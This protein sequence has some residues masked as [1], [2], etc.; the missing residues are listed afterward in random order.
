MLTESLLLAGAGR[1]AR[2]RPRLP[3][4]RLALGHDRTTSTTRRP[5]GWRSTIDG[6]VLAVTVA[7]T[8]RWPRW[9]PACCRPGWRRARNVVEVL[10]EGG[11]GN[12]SRAISLVTRGLVV[13][14]IV[15]TCVLLIGSL[16]QLRSILEAAATSTT[17]TTRRGIMSARMGLMDG[18]YPTP[19]SRKLFY[20]RLLRELRASRSSRPWRSPA[21]CG[22]CSRG[23]GAGRDRGQGLPRQAR[24][25]ERQLRAGVARLLRRASD[26]SCSRAALFTDDDIDAEAA[27]GDRQRGVRAESTSAARARSAGASARATADARRTARG[28]PSS[29]SCRRCGCS[30]RSTTRT[31]TTPAS[32]CRSTRAVRPGPRGADG[33]PVRHGRS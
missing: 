19:E 22:W 26:R 3:V 31:W 24:P 11:R 28:G 33:E 21:G 29:A 12:T 8:R 30:G 10:R 5:R 16:L 15:V 4:D 2:H 7:A 9:S 32:T 18:D 23:Y 6:L 27:G 1:G 20:D 14:Q 17:A 13:A 25:A